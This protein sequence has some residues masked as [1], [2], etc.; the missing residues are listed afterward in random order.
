MSAGLY[1][2]MARAIDARGRTQPME[3]DPDRRSYMISHVLPIEVEV[4]G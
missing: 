3:R 1:T 2:V 4:K